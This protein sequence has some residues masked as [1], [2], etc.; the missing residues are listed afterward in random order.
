MTP[1]L[2]SLASYQTETRVALDAAQR[3]S[4]AI[5]AIYDAQSAQTYEKSD[6]SPVTDADIAA[7]K[8]IRDALTAAF[9]DDAL[10]TEESEDD[11]VRLSNRRVWIVDPIDGTAQFVGRTGKFDVLIAL[12][13]DGEPV[14]GVSLQPT[15]GMTHLAVRG[16]GAW[17]LGDGAWERLT[18]ASAANPPRIVAS[19]YY[20]EP[21]YE[22][23]LTALQSALGAETAPVMDV[24]FQPR[25]IDPA[26]RWY[27]VF[28]GF[29]QDPTVFAAREWD[30][31]TSQIVVEEAGGVLTDCWGRRH[32]YNKR[33]THIS[34]GLVVSPDP[35]LHA[36]VIDALRTHL[37]ETPPSPDPADDMRDSVA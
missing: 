26:E 8:E 29:P 3:A 20:L 13:E 25:A 12:V 22:A 35:A 34:G 14:V 31:A 5:M 4:D 11:D 21:Q 24:G 6:G 28:L 32:Q 37:P 33:D 36:T 10:M 2:P 19:T 7:D 9:P 23:A 30:I 15:T 18:M 17:R 16:Q 1:P 27:D